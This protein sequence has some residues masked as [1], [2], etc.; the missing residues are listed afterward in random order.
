M[1]TKHSSFATAVL[2]IAMLVSV[3]S[4]VPL[5]FETAKSASRPPSPIA[6]ITSKGKVMLSRYVREVV[7]AYVLARFI[8]D[9]GHSHT[10]GS[11]EF[12]ASRKQAVLVS[13]AETSSVTSGRALK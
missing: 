5:S 11:S 1:A 6:S 2:G 10:N 13:K 8:A 7:G 3:R 9:L 4:G 12:Q